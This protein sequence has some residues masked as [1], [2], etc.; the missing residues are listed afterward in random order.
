MF[1]YG[2]IMLYDK[3]S[4]LAQNHK[5]QIQCSYL[6]KVGINGCYVPSLQISK[7]QTL[8]FVAMYVNRE[9]ETY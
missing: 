6:E 1:T 9:H 2:E 7:Q 5:Q 3:C 8:F 4:L